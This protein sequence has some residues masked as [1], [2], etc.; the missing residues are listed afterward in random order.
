[1]YLFF[2]RIGASCVSRSRIVAL[3]LSIACLFVAVLERLHVHEQ[4]TLEVEQEQARAGAHHRIGR[5]QLRMRKA[6]VDV[7]V[8]DVRFVQHQIALDQDRHLAVRIHHVD[9]FGLVEQI[10]IA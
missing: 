2:S 6:L 10:D 7:L 4:F 5:H 1:M 8:D 3:A 9:I